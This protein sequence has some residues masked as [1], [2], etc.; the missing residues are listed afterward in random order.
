MMTARDG[1]QDP[2]SQEEIEP[3]EP[4]A[5]GHRNRPAYPRPAPALRI[6]ADRAGGRDRRHISAGLEIR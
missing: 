5:E 4:R 3:K 2:E 6:L 1:E